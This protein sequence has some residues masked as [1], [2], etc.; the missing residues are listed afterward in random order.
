ME[1]SSSFIVSLLVSDQIAIHLTVWGLLA[2]ALTIA[3]VIRRGIMQMAVIE[4]IKRCE[5]I[6]AR[7]DE[8]KTASERAQAE[9]ALERRQENSANTGSR[10][11]D[12]DFTPYGYSSHA[13]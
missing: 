8:E 13:V 5:R 4:E 2:V 3:L 7:L 6:E 1:Q 11:P 9:R 12:R 10:R